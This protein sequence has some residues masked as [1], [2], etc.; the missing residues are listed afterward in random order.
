MQ[1]TLAAVGRMKNG[2][3]KDLFDHYAARLRWPF[4]VREVEEKKK[5]PAAQL[6][7]REAELLLGVI[8]DAAFVVA[9][10]ERGQ[11]YGSIDFAQKLEG[12]IDR[13]GGNIAFVIGG[14]DGHGD[15]LKARA[16]T[17]WSLGKATWPH[18]LVRAL[19]AEQLFRAHAIQTNHPYHRE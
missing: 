4:V 10:D 5:L 17:L 6:K 1:I 16:D 13:N 9:L 15:A 3:E 19:I 7:A 2:P 18:M 14:A 11:E 12:W 8:P